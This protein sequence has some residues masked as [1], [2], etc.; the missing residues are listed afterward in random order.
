MSN[1]SDRTIDQP[2][3]TLSAP[4]RGKLVAQ[5]SPDRGDGLSES[6]LPSL[7]VPAR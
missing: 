3:N 5:T 4:T 6:R 2:F 1:L 7:Q